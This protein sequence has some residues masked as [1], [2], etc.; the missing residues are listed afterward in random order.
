MLQVVFKAIEA[1]LL[2][3]GSRLATYLDHKYS[4]A[5]QRKALGDQMDAFLSQFET[6]DEAM[7]SRKNMMRDTVPAGACGFTVSLSK[8]SFAEGLHQTKHP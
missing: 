2:Q 4:T 3:P 1:I 7:Q 6:P 8:L 5:E